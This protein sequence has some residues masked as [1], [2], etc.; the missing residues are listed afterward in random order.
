[1]SK[2][3]I[4]QEKSKDR[5]GICLSLN[6]INN[7]HLMKFKCK[8]NHEWETTWKNINKG[9]WCPKCARINSFGPKK[10]TIKDMMD[11][12]S[13]R[14][15]K[16][17]SFKYDGAKSKIDWQC[18]FGHIWQATPNNIKNGSWCSICSS[19]FG[20]RTCRFIFEEIFN[21]TFKKCR[22]K[23]LINSKNNLLEL[24]GFNKE[25]GIA[26]EYNGQQHYSNTGIFPM[27]K[28]D[29]DKIK[30]CAINKVK[31]FVIPFY[32]KNFQQIKCEIKKQAMTLD[33]ALPLEYDS[34][35]FDT[36]KMYSTSND[37][38]L[39][40]EIKK[41]ANHNGGKCLS[42]IYSH[43]LKFNCG[44]CNFIWET[45]PQ[46]I[47]KGCWCP[48]CAHRCLTIQNAI[49]LAS[50]AKGKCLSTIYVNSF[51]KMNWECDKF[52]QWKASYN[53]V[54]SGK[55]CPVC[56]I[57]KCRKSSVLKINVYQK[58]AIANGGECLSKTVNS[59]YD[60]LQWKC[61]NNHFWSNF[62][63]TVKNSKRWCPQ[64]A[65]LSKIV[66]NKVK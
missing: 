16:C 40:C 31:L 3:K 58:V 39:L 7:V 66:E 13:K 20:E 23:W 30:L 17:L 5:G 57:E 24:D 19:G 14:G 64:C 32:L 45:T 8:E 26:F 41:I 28:Y 12:A 25:L 11:I 34:L 54:Q 46:T 38:I 48:N 33:V 15:G 4:I 59:C 2:M 47:K 9:S 49:D 50:I 21:T 65:R 60:K 10:Y 62:A 52:H 44:V 35:S 37:N 18:S 27:S 61:K 29:K 36:N 43:K 6:Y 55:W 53:Q 1:M 63:Y 51:T 56:G 22:P 42:E